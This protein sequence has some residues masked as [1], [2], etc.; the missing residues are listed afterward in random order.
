[1]SIENLDGLA[2]A[3]STG[4][5]RE[6]FFAHPVFVYLVVMLGGILCIGLAEHQPEGRL[7]ILY[8][9]VGDWF[10]RKPLKGLGEALII[11]GIIGMT[12]DRYNLKRHRK[13]MKDMEMAFSHM[14]E[15]ITSNV[16]NDASAHGIMSV[17]KTFLSDAILRSISKDVLKADLTR[18]N[19]NIELVLRREQGRVRVTQ[20]VDSEVSNQAWSPRTYRFA[21]IFDKLIGGMRAAESEVKMFSVS[22]KVYGEP[23]ISRMTEKS[24]AGNAMV[25]TD[26]EVPARKSVRIIFGTSE[27]RE[28][29]D[30]IFWSTLLP[31]DSMQLAIIVPNSD[32]DVVV[33][34]LHPEEPEEDSGSTMARKWLLN[35]AALP[36]Q[37]FLVKWRVR[38][39]VVD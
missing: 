24:S 17:Y 32:I 31:T 16:A 20:T 23:D 2:Q 6:S 5:A 39:D 36:G 38:P 19:Y 8:Q 28:E 18:K 30:T 4:E 34:T 7:A 27:L 25:R 21:F 11:A 13:S 26:I 12:I 14:A 10:M 35:G 37:G 3:S 33:E 22:G 1:M 9:L 15:G 29:F